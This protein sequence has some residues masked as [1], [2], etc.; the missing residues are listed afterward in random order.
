MTPAEDLVRSAVARHGPIGFDEVVD[1][2]LYDRAH[3]FY[4]SGGQAG[5]R[6]D[7]LTSPEVG[8]LFGAVVARSI[9]AWWEQLGEPDLLTV[10]EAAAGSGT[11]A[12]AVLAAAPRSARALRYVLVER[13]AAQ[14]Q[15]HRARLPLELPEAA[16][17]SPPDPDDEV[18]PTAP[19]PVGPIVVSVPSLPRLPGPCL[20]LANELLDN[21]PFGLL[22]RRHGTW[23]EVRVGVDSGSLA[24]VLVPRPSEP[25]VARDGARIP[26]QRRR[27]GLGAG[28]R[29][30]AGPD[31]RVVV[32]DY[33]SS[34]DDLAARPW[35]E[36][37]R[38]YRSHA[39]GGTPL[40]DVGLQD[41]TCEVAVDQLPDT[42][43]ERTQ[44]DWLRANGIEELVAEGKAI[45]HERA[46][47]GDLAAV[48]A[49]SRVTEAE[50]LLDPAGL[51]GFRVLEWGGTS[52]VRRSP[53]GST[54]GGGSGAGPPGRAPLAGRP[55]RTSSPRSRRGRSTRWQGGRRRCPR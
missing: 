50:A 20:V 51:G 37:V 41:I 53:T 28:P 3:G 47:I 12:R 13:S 22:E 14:R 19:S 32:I 40:E 25:R 26:V 33:G 4:A 46:S 16:F 35:T 43:S 42:A 54:P 48:R 52:G 24:E 10:V 17:A 27:G 6:G 11:L 45:W 44:A 18:E 55:R 36:W 21:L 39:R 34:T 8:P 2:A 15:Q 23:H 49:R 29:A 30:L 9:D 1:I 38:T 31:G 5:R 7:F